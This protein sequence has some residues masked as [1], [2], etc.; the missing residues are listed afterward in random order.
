MNSYQRV[1]QILDDSVGGSSV[2]IGAHGAFWRGLSR[3]QF[4]K[5]KVFGR[6]IIVLG[7]GDASLL[8]KALKGLSPFGNDLSTPPDGAMWP[9]MPAFLPPVSDP[10]IAFIEDWID[11]GCLE[12]SVT[13]MNPAAI[14]QASTNGWRPTSAPTASSR[15]DDVWFVDAQVGWGVNSNGQILYTRDGGD[16]WTEQFHDPNVYLRCIAFANASRGWVGTIGDVSHSKILFDTFDGGSTWNPVN[17]LPVNAPVRICG[18]WIVN[19]SVVYMAGS[20]IPSD[21]VRMMK[22]ADGGKT[23]AAWDMRNWADNLIDV[24][25][26]DERRGWVVGGRT[27]DPRDPN[28]SKPKLRPV[29]LYTADGGATWEDRVAA[30]RLQFP[31][32]EWGWKIQF[33]NDLIGFISLQNYGAGAI[34][35]TSD[36]GLTWTRHPINDP[37][38]NANLE[39]IGFLDAQHGWVGGWGD[40]PKKKRTS[41]ETFDGG[42]TWRDANEI[43]GTINRFRFIGGNPPTGY[44][45]GE[46]IYK[47]I[48]SSTPL[49]IGVPVGHVDGEGIK[50]MVPSR[51]AK[52]SVRV[53]DP[54]GPMVRTIVEEVRPRSGPRTIVWDGSDDDGVA[55]PRYSHILRVTVDDRSESTLVTPQP[56]VRNAFSN[57]RPLLMNPSLVADLPG[58]GRDAVLQAL[59][60]ALELEHSTIPL[61]LYSLYSLQDSQ[62]AIIEIL[63]RVV[64]EEMLHMTLVCNLINSLGGNPVIYSP[65]FVPQY[66]GHSLPGGVE[67]NL[68]VHLRPFSL[69]Q[70][71]DFLTIESPE[72]TRNFPVRALASYDIASQLTIGGFYR[73]IRA[74][75]QQLGDDAF[76][77]TGTNQLTSGISNI[78]KVIDVNS[79]LKAIDIIVDQGEGSDQTPLEMGTEDP[80]HFYAFMSVKIGKTLKAKAGVDPH[81]PIEDQFEYTDPQI[82][83]DQ[84][85]VYPI[86]EDPSAVLYTG[87][88]KAACDEFNIAYTDLLRQ[89]DRVFNGHPGEIRTAVTQMRSV[90]RPLATKLVSGVRVPGKNIGPSFEFNAGGQ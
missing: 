17:N 85:S 10:D 25:F 59:Q 70:L 43:G 22:T 58:G 34:L 2:A 77:A 72:I 89:L 84:S 7:N 60:T 57:L 13:S 30:S 15:Y 79:A 53:W 55:R 16:S 12:T 35:T 71:D 26:I 46:T 32:G 36:G 68:R 67:T 50:L 64:V 39:G 9:R 66:K 44:A 4:V 74:A 61:Y 41:S 3:D 23:W 83:F 51:S 18:L 21:P 62:A 73:E 33:I 28:P 56:S 27:D 8:I 78:V 65:S 88:E 49:L 20:N 52:L 37:Q 63:Q 90:L 47:Y 87:D 48:G 29:I 38:G 14:L 19:E 31:L 5:L 1:V 54:D 81:A 75:L 42:K 40:A 82:P 11:H 80:S 24:Y 45:A 69:K 76:D 86:P 6:D